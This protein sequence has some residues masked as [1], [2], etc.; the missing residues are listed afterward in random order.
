M[1]CFTIG[2][3]GSSLAQAYLPAFYRPAAAEGGASPGRRPAPNPNLKLNPTPTPN[4][5]PNPGRRP[6][7]NPNLNLDPTPTPTPTPNPGRRPA[8]R[9]AAL[10][11][12]LRGAR[13]PAM[14]LSWR[15]WPVYWAQQVYWLGAGVRGRG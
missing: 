5:N 10:M 1:L 2:D 11:R 9:S 7:P 14:P 3:V 13:L 8:R 4:P 15:S 6:A 12:V